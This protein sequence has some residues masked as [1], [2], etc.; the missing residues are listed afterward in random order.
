MSVGEAW[1]NRGIDHSLTCQKTK[2]LTLNCQY[3]AHNTPKNT[4]TLTHTHTHSPTHSHTHTH[5]HTLTHT[6][7]HIYTYF[8]AIRCDHDIK[9]Y[10]SVISKHLIC[11]PPDRPDELHCSDPI[12][13][14]KDLLYHTFTTIAVNKFP[15]R[16][17]LG[18]GREE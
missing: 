14:H 5:T 3:A 12:V 15:R 13:G 10:S 6:L 16:E 4:H 1:E 17:G 7:T 8:Q 11:P 2:T 18:R 9:L